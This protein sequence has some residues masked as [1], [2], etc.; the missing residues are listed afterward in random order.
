MSCE[1]RDHGVDGSGEIIRDKL[2]NYNADKKYKL[3]SGKD[4]LI[5]IKTAPE[6]LNSFFTFKVFCLRECVSDSAWVCVPRVA[7]YYLFKPSAIEKMLGYRHAIYKGFSPN[8]IAVR[9]PMSDILQ[10]VEDKDALYREWRPK[11]VRYVQQNLEILTRDK[12]K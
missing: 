5:E 1:V 7:G 2:A 8:D 10:M 9:I 3:A 11:A 6:W 4:M 12:K